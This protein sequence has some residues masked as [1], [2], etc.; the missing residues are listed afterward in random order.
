MK[1]EK[2]LSGF[3]IHSTGAEDSNTCFVPNG[4]EWAIEL[5]ATD[6]NKTFSRIAVDGGWEYTLEA[7]G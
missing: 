1:I 2:P 4:A 3:G 7:H 6:E 5:W